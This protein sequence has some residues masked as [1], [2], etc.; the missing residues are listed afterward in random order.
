VLFGAALWASRHAAADGIEEKPSAQALAQAKEA[1]SRFNS[2]VGEWRG[3]GQPQRSSQRGAWT[4]QANWMWD[5]SGG[6]TALRCDIEGGKQIKKCVLTY[7]GKSKLY[8]LDATLS[9]ETARQYSGAPD[10]E[11][12][13]LESNADSAGEVHC[14]TLTQLNPKRTLLLLQKRRQGSDFYSRVAEVGYTRAGTSLAAEG[15]SGPQ[16]I[17]TGGEGT[18]KVMHK[19]QT[20]YVC[21]TGCKQAFD[22]DP[23]G[24]IADYKRRMA[25]KKQPQPKS[26]Q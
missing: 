1:L 26:G 19:G 25:E 15:G 23:E 10:G 16:C 14:L 9:D 13:V 7:D 4:E 24:I 22:D 3:V 12:L 20:Y 8:R 6:G 17:V 5:F 18:I 21:C 11:K 2:L